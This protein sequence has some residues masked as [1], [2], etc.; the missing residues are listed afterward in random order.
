MATRILSFNLNANPH[1]SCELTKPLFSFSLSFSVYQITQ[2]PLVF[3]TDLISADNMIWLFKKGSQNSLQL[4]YLK[5]YVLETP[6]VS[7]IK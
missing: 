6:F 4:P 3:E 5:V 7:Y 1:L 2:D